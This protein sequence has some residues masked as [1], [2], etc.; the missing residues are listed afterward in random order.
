MDNFDGQKIVIKDLLNR[1]YFFRVPEYQRPFSWDT[2]NF[3]DLIQD[4]LDAEQD[5]EYFLGTFVLHEKKDESVYDIVDGQQRLTT[6]MILFACLRDKINS[7][8]FKTEL[9]NKIK[10]TANVVDG[11]PERIRL[12]VRD[13]EIFSELITEING[14]NT[15][16]DPKRLPEPEWRYVEAIRVFNA[17]LD[18][19][20]QDQ[21][22]KFSQFISQKCIIIYLATKTFDDAFK[23]FTIVNDRGKQLRRIDVLK[24]KNISPK[25]VSSDR[26]RI[27]LAQKWEEW[28]KELGGEDFERV[29]YF[30]RFILLEEKPY[31]DLLIEYEDKIFKKNKLGN[32]QVFIDTVCEYASIFNDLFNDMNY[33]ESYSNEIKVN[34]LLFIMNNEFTSYEWRA[35]L[36]QYVKKFNTENIEEFLTNLELLYLDGLIKGLNKDTRTSAFGELMKSINSAQNASAVINSKVLVFDKSKLKETLNTDIYGRNFTKYILLRLELITSEQDAEHK[37]VAKSVEHVLPQ[38]IDSSSTWSS[39]FTEEEHLEWLDR[40]ANLVLLSKSKN[41]SAGN[42]EFVSKKETYL[43]NR[44]SDYPCSIKVLDYDEWTPNIL[45]ERQTQLLEKILNPVF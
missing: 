28:E 18:K 3:T 6:L 29:L 38:T 25:I 14:T 43:K 2:E 16:K 37:Y 24:A 40:L 11:I 12:E 36:M 31:K 17:E 10:Q 8:S 15:E 39:W 42:K 45:E 27:S 4:L 20:S 34:N 7:D 35:C 21:L 19:L 5:Q 33:F 23:L 13:R 44:V 26:V 9:H 22:E 32:G 30:L 41:S 1:E